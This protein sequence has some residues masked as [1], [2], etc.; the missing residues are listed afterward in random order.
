MKNYT[1]KR[2]LTGVFSVGFLLL[3]SCGHS[4]TPSSSLA[5]A[6]SYQLDRYSNASFLDHSPKGSLQVEDITSESINIT[7]K[8]T[9]GKI[10][11]NYYYPKVEVVFTGQNAFDQDMY[12]LLYNGIYLGQAGSD[13]ISRFIEIYPTS[14]ITLRAVE[15]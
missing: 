6:G 14:R 13:G 12:A 10:K 4:V 9:A 8:G 11:F 5:T 15:Y 2:V 7:A 1:I 3:S